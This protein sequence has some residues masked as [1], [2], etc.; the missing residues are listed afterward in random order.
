MAYS[1]LLYP[2]DFS[3]IFEE[4]EQPGQKRPHALNLYIQRNEFGIQPMGKPPRIAN[5]MLALWTMVKTN[6]HTLGSS[7][8]RANH[9]AGHI[10][11]QL[12]FGFIRCQAQRDF[13]QRRE[14]AFTKEIVQ[15][16]L[17]ALGGIDIA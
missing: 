16:R 2:L 10:P 3:S 6:Q 17:N 14:I 8:M 9:M 15:R 4:S 1:L 11:L 13:A 5:D 12:R 7:P